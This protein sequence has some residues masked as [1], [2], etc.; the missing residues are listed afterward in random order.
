M[1]W[2]CLLLLLVNLGYLAWMLDQR[3]Q[4]EVRY[5]T[6]AMDVPDNVPRLQ[7][8][9]ELEHPPMRQ[10]AVPAETRAEDPP[11]EDSAPQS[12]GEDS[13]ALVTTLPGISDELPESLLMLTQLE[14]NACFSF[15]PFTDRDRAG[16]F[17]GWLKARQARSSLRR[18][19]DDDNSLFW[20]YLKPRSN[21]E[22]RATLE[23]LR[24]QG[25]QDIS[26]MDSGD[27]KN[28]ISLGLFST[29]ASVN[30]R[31]R[32]LEDKG[33][34]PVV[35]PYDQDDTVYWVDARINQGKLIEEMSDAYPS[36]LNFMPIAC[37]KIALA[38]SDQ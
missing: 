32:E 33:Y 35:V 16:D 7:L 29:Q 17:L 20:V 2:I 27:L 19:A 11:E 36:G 31:L 25:V 13:L 30:R 4:Q 23:E 26:L 5:Q 28:A 8:V 9:S 24:D 38:Q 14:T 3:T 21:A 12:G 37:A 18:E 15:G 6:S 22:A 34:Q 10:I 1:R